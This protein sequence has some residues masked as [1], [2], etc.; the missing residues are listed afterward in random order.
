MDSLGK[1]VP[2]IYTESDTDGSLAAFISVFDNAHAEVITAIESVATVNQPRLTPSKFIQDIAAHY[3]S[4]FPFMTTERWQ[5]GT[6]LES[7]VYIYST[8]GT[9]PGIVNAIRYLC[10]IDVILLQDFEYCWILNV[11]P[12]AGGSI[13]SGTG[14]GAAFGK[15]FGS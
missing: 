2:A 7:L 12:L 10:G 15:R 8:R 6:K 4:P 9:K 11:S 14:F 5:D 13:T 3:S 1:L